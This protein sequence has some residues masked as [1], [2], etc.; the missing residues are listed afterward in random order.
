MDRFKD[1][2]LLNYYEG[3]FSGAIQDET[4]VKDAIEFYFGWLTGIANEYNI[5][6]DYEEC[7][8]GC[9]A[10]HDDIE[11]YLED[12]I[13]YGDLANIADYILLT[14]EERYKDAP[15]KLYEFDVL[16]IIDNESSVSDLIQIIYD[17]CLKEVR[18]KYEVI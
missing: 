16:E 10:L 5:P 13:V 3:W 1:L 17:Y 11:A 18:K 8:D 7:P 14:I 4:Y 9:D 15:Q 2:M 12:N 6:T